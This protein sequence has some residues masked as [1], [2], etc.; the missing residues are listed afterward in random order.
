MSAV[1]VLVAV[2]IIALL[3]LIGIVFGADSRDGVDGSNE[4][5]RRIHHPNTWW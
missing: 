2:V 4:Y 5:G 3:P 1:G